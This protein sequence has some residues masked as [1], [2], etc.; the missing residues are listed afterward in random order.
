MIGLA[1]KDSRGV[2]S[3]GWNSIED[4]AN[5]VFASGAIRTHLHEAKWEAWR[6]LKTERTICS[7]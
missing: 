6:L 3:R 1:R 7:V 5:L 4:G 2:Q